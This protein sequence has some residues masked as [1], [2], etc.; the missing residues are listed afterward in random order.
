MKSLFSSLLLVNTWIHSFNETPPL[1]RSQWIHIIDGL[2]KVISQRSKHRR[3]QWSVGPWFRV[4]LW[5]LAERDSTV[6]ECD[7]LSGS[8]DVNLWPSFDVPVSA[9]M[10]SACVYVSRLYNASC[11]VQLPMQM[12]PVLCCTL[13][14]VPLIRS[15]AV[16]RNVSWQSTFLFIVSFFSLVFSL[17][18]VLSFKHFFLQ[19]M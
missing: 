18:N 7:P 8:V 5:T 19:K 16:R 4:E 1:P 9:S 10:F 12:G 13:D 11:E 3:L 17:L 15:D 6:K 14:N 2:L